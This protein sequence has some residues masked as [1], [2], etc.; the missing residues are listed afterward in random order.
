[1]L[2]PGLVALAVALLLSSPARSIAEPV[3]VASRACVR[4]CTT[5]VVPEPIALALLATGIMGLLATGVVYL[6]RRRKTTVA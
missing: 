5:N 6:R 3:A 1:M 2:K 4:G